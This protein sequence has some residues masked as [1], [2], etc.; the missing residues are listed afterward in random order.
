MSLCSTVYL[1]VVAPYER[2]S[3]ISPYWGLIYVT[4]GIFLIPRRSSISDANSKRSASVFGL[5][6]GR[7][8]NHYRSY[9]SDSYLQLPINGEISPSQVEIFDST[10]VS[11]FTDVYK[12][13]GRL[14][15]GGQ[16]KGGI[17]AFTKITLTERVPNFVCMKA[18]VTNEKLFL[19][20]LDLPKGTI[21]V[22]DKGFQKFSQYRQWN[23]S[24]IHYVTRLNDSAIFQII[25]QR[26]LQHTCEDGVQMDADIELSYRC[27]ESKKEETVQARMGAYIDPASRKKLVFLTNLLDVKAMTGC[28]LYK[29]RWTIQPLFKQLKQNFE[30]IF[31]E[32]NSAFRSPRL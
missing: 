15:K 19:S 31:L 20:E 12:N 11:L 4:A 6:Y 16:R 32:R 22:F 23:Q 9:F 7:L 14:P 21:A 8:Y 2:L 25:Q 10:T 17:K 13:C 5:L 30:S 1:P 3:R 27:P 29:H 18:A 28:L 26:P 24:G